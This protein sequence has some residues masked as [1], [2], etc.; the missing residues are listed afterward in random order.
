SISSW[1]RGDHPLRHINSTV[2]TPKGLSGSL[3]FW[4]MSSQQPKFPPLRRGV[5]RK[6]D[7]E[8]ILSLMEA[9]NAVLVST[10]ID[11][12]A[13]LEDIKKKFHAEYM[14]LEI[15]HAEYEATYRACVDDRAK[16]HR[17]PKLGPIL[18][19]ALAICDEIRKHPKSFDK[20]KPTVKKIMDDLTSYM[21]EREKL[22]H[23]VTAHSSPLAGSH[24]TPELQ[25]SSEQSLDMPPHDDAQ[26]S[27]SRV[28]LGTDATSSDDLPEPA[29]FTFS[30]RTIAIIDEAFAPRDFAPEE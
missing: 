29:E 19:E 24:E 30:A 27:D 5:V 17:D 11:R 25:S 13:K 1:L 28:Y 7:V 3:F 6:E 18:R 8:R 10:D 15:R 2:T 14:S 12:D 9:H 20:A 26:S 21:Q 16:F 4:A 22:L 23:G